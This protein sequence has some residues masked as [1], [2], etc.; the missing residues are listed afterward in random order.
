M[1]V[2]P[3]IDERRYDIPLKEATVAGE[4][5]KIRYTVR[6]KQLAGTFINAASFATYSEWECFIFDK[7]GDGGKTS[8]ERQ[9]AA[10]IYVATAS[11]SVVAVPYAIAT[12]SSTATQSL[13][14]G[15]R[16][17]ELWAKVNSE[18]TRLSYGEFPVVD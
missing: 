10:L 15:M 4:Q 17:H 1:A 13:K 5:R 2:N 3:N 14:A 16:A 8:A 6:E 11:I 18:W 12:L 9:A 7:L